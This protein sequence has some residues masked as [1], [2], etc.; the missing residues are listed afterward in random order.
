[1]KIQK[2]C[3]T[4]ALSARNTPAASARDGDVITFE[5]LDCYGCVVTDSGSGPSPVRVANGRNGNPACGPLFVEGAMPGMTLAVDVLDIR[6][7]GYAT[8]CVRPD[9]G[10]MAKAVSEREQVFFPLVNGCADMFGHTLA[11]DPMIGVIGVAPLGEGVDNE[12]PGTHGGNMDCR[13][14]TAGS[15]LYLPVA[16]PGALLS[17]GD[18]HALMGDGEVAVCGLECASEIDARVRVL[19]VAVARWPVLRAK[20]GFWYVLASAKTLDEAAELARYEML[21]VLQRRTNLSDN[22]LV[23]LLSVV[24]QLEICQIVD[25]LMTVRMGVPESA[26]PGLVR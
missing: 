15:T 16:A 2:E 8:M 9:A 24:G 22:Q 14:I 10:A 12:T 5:T 7:S 3:W 23:M 11:L 4:D 25:P 21:D 26:F 6:V 19:D 17:M 1:M 18:V 20:N 13:M